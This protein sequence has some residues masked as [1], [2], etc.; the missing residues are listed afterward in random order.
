MNLK[1]Q[2][3]VSVGDDFLYCGCDGAFFLTSSVG[4]IYVNL[5]SH[6]LLCSLRFLCHQRGS[7]IKTV[8]TPSFF[9]PSFKVTQALTEWGDAVATASDEVDFRGGRASSWFVHKSFIPSQPHSS[10]THHA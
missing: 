2:F 6:L 9:S 1:Y 3:A 5:L 8:R 4:S 10:L 7:G